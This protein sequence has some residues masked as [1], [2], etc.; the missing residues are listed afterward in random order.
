MIFKKEF[1]FIRY[2]RKIGVCNFWKLGTVQLLLIHDM[3]DS[4]NILGPEF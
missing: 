4:Q 3:V 1:S 2:F